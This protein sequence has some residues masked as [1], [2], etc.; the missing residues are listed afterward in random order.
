MQEKGDIGSILIGSAILFG[1]SFMS[2]FLWSIDYASDEEWSR[3]TYFNAGSWTA[4][5]GYTSW[6]YLSVYT[7]L[8]CRQ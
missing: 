6:G 4:L 7:H 1:S 2:Y 8:Y 3:Y 5:T